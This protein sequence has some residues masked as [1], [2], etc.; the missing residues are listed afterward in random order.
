[1][2]IAKLVKNIY[3]LPFK[4]H[5]NHMNLCLMTNINVEKLKLPI[6]SIIEF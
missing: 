5:D 6:Y 1:M 3:V 2:K 4:M